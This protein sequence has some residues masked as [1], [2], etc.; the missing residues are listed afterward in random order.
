[1]SDTR[2]QLDKV[3]IAIGS[4]TAQRSELI[5]EADT[6]KRQ[7]DAL[8][9]RIA[10]KAEDE[11]INS[12]EGGLCDGCAAKD[13]TCYDGCADKMRAWSLEKAKAKG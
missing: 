9:N 7:V 6:L 2:T 13:D 4:L 3:M 10:S 5:V 8:L 11:A 12:V 1:M